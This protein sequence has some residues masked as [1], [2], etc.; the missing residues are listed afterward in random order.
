M[1]TG[2]ISY[3]YSTE[4][5]WFRTTNLGSWYAQEVIDYNGWDAPTN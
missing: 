2:W 5:R 4:S 3:D 1:A